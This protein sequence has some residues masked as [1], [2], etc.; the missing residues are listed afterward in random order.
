[1]QKG[2]S[3]KQFGNFLY[4]VKQTYHR[5][6]KSFHVHLLNKNNENT[7][8]QKDL[9]TVIN[10]IL[11]CDSLIHNS[12]KPERNPKVLTLLDLR[13]MDKLR[14]IH[15]MENCSVIKGNQLW[16]HIMGT[17]LKNYVHTRS[18]TQKTTYC[19][20]LRIWNPR[21][22]ETTVT[23]SRAVLASSCTWEGGWLQRTMGEC[24]G[25]M[26]MFQIAAAVVV[27]QLCTVVTPWHCAPKKGEFDVCKLPL[28]KTDLKL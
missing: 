27:T 14:Q 4:K 15:T 26:E 17:D 16:I 19:K 9:Y 12:A 11:V 6:Q 18:Q 22:G 2:S 28:N 10:Y 3:G 13:W 1:M 25:V 7:C 23:E 8:A 5:T 20:N 24:F 21:K